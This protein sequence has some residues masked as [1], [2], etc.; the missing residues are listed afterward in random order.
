MD[1]FGSFKS[2]RCVSIILPPGA[3]VKLLIV[4]G[5]SRDFAETQTS[6]ISVSG[7]S[8]DFT[9]RWRSTRSVSLLMYQVAYPT[10]A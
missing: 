9:A 6:N 4:A 7:V 5:A 3:E 2:A 10:I 8:R 1:S